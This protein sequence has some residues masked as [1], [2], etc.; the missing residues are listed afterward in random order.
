ME[1]HHHNHNSEVE[2]EGLSSRV[3]NFSLHEDTPNSKNH[4]PPVIF[5]LSCLFL[6][7]GFVIMFVC[8]CVIKV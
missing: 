2:A 5:I 1:G 4:Y 6:N 3:S 8:M 7:L